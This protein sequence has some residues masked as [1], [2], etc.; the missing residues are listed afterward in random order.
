MFWND[1][2]CFSHDLIVP[3]DPGYRF[4]LIFR[5]F[6]LFNSWLQSN[7]GDIAAINERKKTAPHLYN[8]NMDPQMTGQI[9]HFILK[10]D[11]TM[12]DETIIG[13]GKAEGTDLTLRGSRYGQN[14][15]FEDIF[16]FVLPI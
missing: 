4:V 9:I 5:I 13:N 11:N 10:D 2:K 1:N 8:L 7:Y 14:D 16:S 12:D 6:A 3:T 15:S